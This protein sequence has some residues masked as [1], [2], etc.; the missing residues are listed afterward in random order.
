VRPLHGTGGTRREDSSLHLLDPE[1]ADRQRSRAIRRADHRDAGIPA[2]Q[3]D[4]SCLPRLS[5]PGRMRGKT[6]PTRQHRRAGPLLS[7]R[8][9]RY[10]H[11]CMGARQRTGSPQGRVGVYD[12][13]VG[14]VSQRWTGRPPS[15]ASP[16]TGSLKKCIRGAPS[17][18]D[19]SWG[20]RRGSPRGGLHAAAAIGLR[21]AIAVNTA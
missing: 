7:I 6:S 5:L 3:D 20:R 18:R 17:V 15:I 4:P 10:H 19:L 11:H 1:S 2:G 8:A 16:E 21:R 13:R 9:R 12:D 14:S